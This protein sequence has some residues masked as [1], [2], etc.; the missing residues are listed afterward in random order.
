MDRQ[1]KTRAGG[2][3]YKWKREKWQ[4][5]EWNGNREEYSWDC[6][7]FFHV[8]SVAHERGMWKHTKGEIWGAEKEA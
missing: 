8:G 7:F 1:K 4:K 5:M 6:T 3:Y 2:K